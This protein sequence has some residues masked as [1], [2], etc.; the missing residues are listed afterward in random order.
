MEET[1]TQ[2]RV[3]V[4]EYKCEIYQE[5]IT[6]LIASTQA[7]Y[8]VLVLNGTIDPERDST[9]FQKSHVRNMALMDQMFAIARDQASV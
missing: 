8:E 6:N 7:L 1:S 9:Q 2:S 4:L 5:M 3:A